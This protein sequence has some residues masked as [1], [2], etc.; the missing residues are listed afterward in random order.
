MTNS[1][2]DEWFKSIFDA[3]DAEKM[4]SKAQRIEEDMSTL[5]EV[6]LAI[7]RDQAIETCKHYY[8]MQE[9]EMDLESMY[10]IGSMVT[11]MI[12]TLEEALLY[13]GINLDEE[14]DEED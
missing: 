14:M 6:T 10:F 3:E 9:E 5:Y 11:A 4:I 12:L 7:P 8:R 1:S 13:D 2:N